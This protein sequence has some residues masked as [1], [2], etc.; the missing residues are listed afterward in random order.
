M[1]GL[2]AFSVYMAI[3]ALAL[4]KG[5]AAE[6][7]NEE[8]SSIP[9]GILMEAG[10][11]W[12]TSTGGGDLEIFLEDGIF[13]PSR[14]ALSPEGE[15]QAKKLAA[16]LKKLEPESV[17][18]MAAVSGGHDNPQYPEP[19]HLAAARAAELAAA[20]S[21]EG[22]E[23]SYMGSDRFGKAAVRASGKRKPA[24]TGAKGEGSEDGK[25]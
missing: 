2:N 18:V 17:T 1:R 5:L 16:L 8:A 19:R 23:V 25:E 3:A 22:L 21:R 24:E 6:S 20:L 7:G 13:K 11:S 10:M 9:A 14:P 15:A 4:S 12:E